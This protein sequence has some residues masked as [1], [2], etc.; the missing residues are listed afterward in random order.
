MKY[1]FFL[2]NYHDIINSI[3]T[4]VDYISVSYK[5]GEKYE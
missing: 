1:I 5:R 3:K 2:F 4:D